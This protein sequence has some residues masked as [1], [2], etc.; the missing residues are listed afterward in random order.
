MTHHRR[1]LLRTDLNEA[2]EELAVVLERDNDLA[3]SND[4]QREQ[5]AYLKKDRGVPVGLI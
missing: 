2:Q 5:C 4:Y 1:P 3:D